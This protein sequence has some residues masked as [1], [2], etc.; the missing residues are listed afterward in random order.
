MG[1]R[2]LKTRKADALEMLSKQGD[3]WLASAGGAGEA[4]VIAASA[5]W[6]GTDVV[7]STRSNTATARNLAANP[8]VRLAVR[9][10]ADAVVVDARVADISAVEDVPDVAGGFA[11]AV[12]WDPREAGEGWMFF[13]LR[14][15]RIQ[16]YRGYEEMEGRDVM[17]R[18]EWVV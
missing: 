4:H 9:S 3:L 13:R 14:P 2:D 16:V 15:T 18:S 8:V 5:W 12:G 7:V 6:D 10:P 17:R 1:V 11:A